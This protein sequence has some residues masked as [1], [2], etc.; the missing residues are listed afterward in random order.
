MENIS[1]SPYHHGNLK[2]ALVQ[3]ALEMVEND[4][5]ESITLRDLT[6]K[7]G[8]S[9]SALYR[10][11]DSKDELM[12]AVVKAG[13]E[14]FHNFIAPA[15]MNNESVLN[16]LY[17]VGKSYI[18]FAIKNP[19]LYRMMFGHEL[20]NEREDSCDIKD[21]DDAPSF[22]ALVSLVVEAQNSKL[23][24]KDDPILQS[25][26]IWSMMHGLVK[27]LIDGHVHVKDNLDALFEMT[28]QTILDGM[29]YTE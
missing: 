4:G 26:V 8:T 24:K 12:K 11:F 16:K 7:I 23:F 28:F 14:K 5:V 29:R 10:H 9:R 6:K 22:H 25:T 15:I 1:Q 17:A 18:E 20:Q 19:N 21:E 27:L 3:T 13:F 2:D